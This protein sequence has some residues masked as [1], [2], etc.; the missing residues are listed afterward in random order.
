MPLSKAETSRRWR[1]RHP[2]TVR[3]QRRARYI[4]Q[5]YNLSTVQYNAMLTAQGGV[6]AICG[7]PPSY[8]RLDIDHD[9]KDG[10]IR[11]LLCPCCNNALGMLRD[12]W[13]LAL[14]AAKYLR[15]ELPACRAS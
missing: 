5:L 15:R 1:L 9:H 14:R 7:D 10:S 4:K 3:V 6:C 2:E 13:V 12:R 8:R 11:G